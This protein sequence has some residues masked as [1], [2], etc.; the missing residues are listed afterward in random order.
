MIN[1]HDKGVAEVLGKSIEKAQLVI[2]GSVIK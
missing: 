2:E 1:P